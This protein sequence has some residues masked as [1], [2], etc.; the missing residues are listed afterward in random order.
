MKLKYVIGAF[1]LT[2]AMSGCAGRKG[3]V[4]EAEKKADAV[5]KQLDEAKT[6]S[7]AEQRVA[8]LEKQLADAKKELSEAK[9]QT[10]AATSPAPAP[11]PAAPVEPPP[12]PKPK[13]YVIEAGTAIPVRTTTA[14]STKTAQT[15]APFSATLTAP[16]T[17]DGVVLAKSGADAS[18]V[19]TLSDPGGRVKGKASISVTLKSIRGVHGPIEIATNTREA[20]AKSTVKKDVVRGGIMTG[21]GAAIGAIAGGGKGAAI[22]AGIGGAAGVGTALATKGAPAEFPAETPLTFTTKAPVTVTVQP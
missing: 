21:A 5:Q 2:L 19:V 4:G 6:Q 16:L 12:P 11:A 14:L 1:L 15:G 17:V 18:G 9:G 20:V 22:G 7:G 13:E 8:E 3:D 10:P